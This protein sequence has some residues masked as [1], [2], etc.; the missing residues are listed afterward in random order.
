MRDLRQDA[1]GDLEWFTT[2]LAW[3]DLV[4]M[5]V[6]LLFVGIVLLLMWSR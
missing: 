1:D 5:T 6:G 3:T 4:S 2:L